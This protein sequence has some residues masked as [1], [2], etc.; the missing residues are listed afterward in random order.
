M[1]ARTLDPERSWIVKSH[2]VWR[3]ERVLA[4]TLNPRMDYEI[5]HRL[6]RGT[7]VNKDA[8]P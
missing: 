5:P 2:I 3:E 7:G 4:R 8:W 6:E 1:S